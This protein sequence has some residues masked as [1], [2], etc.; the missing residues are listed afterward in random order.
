MY[1]IMPGVIKYSW[2]GLFKLFCLSPQLNLQA[3]GAVVEGDFSN[4][5]II[6]VDQPQP[7]VIEY[8]SPLIL[9]VHRLMFFSN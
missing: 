9:H 5:T 6:S 1:N 3:A 2:T 7:P 4:A 8:V